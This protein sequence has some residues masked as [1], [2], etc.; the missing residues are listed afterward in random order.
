MSKPH[1]EHSLI[2]NPK[3]YLQRGSRAG[4]QHFYYRSLSGS[5]RRKRRATKSSSKINGLLISAHVPLIHQALLHCAK[6]A[7]LLHSCLQ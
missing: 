2:K 5:G 1:S 7:Y 3:K 4:D 6:N